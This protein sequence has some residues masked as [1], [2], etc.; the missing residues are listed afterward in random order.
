MPTEALVTEVKRIVGL[1]K[2]GNADDAY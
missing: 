2:A 1:S